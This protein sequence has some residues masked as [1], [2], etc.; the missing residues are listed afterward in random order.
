[1]NV[2][3]PVIEIFLCNFKSRMAAHS[4]LVS[5]QAMKNKQMLVIPGQGKA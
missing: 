4:I 3:L 1:V 2:A 5:M